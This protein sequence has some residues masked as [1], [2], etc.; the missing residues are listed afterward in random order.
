MEIGGSRHLVTHPVIS[1]ENEELMRLQLDDSRMNPYEIVFPQH[2]KQKLI[3][4]KRM[5][6]RIQS[7]TWR[8]SRYDLSNPDSRL[9]GV[10]IGKLEFM[11]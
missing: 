6:L 3:H 2:L 11:K 7:E 4:Q 5:R 9:L 1:A 10:K 8:P